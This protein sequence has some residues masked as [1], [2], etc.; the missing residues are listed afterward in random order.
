MEAIVRRHSSSRMG[1]PS[2]SPETSRAA[3]PVPLRKTVEPEKTGGGGF[4]LVL[5]DVSLSKVGNPMRK[6]SAAAPGVVKP[7]AQKPSRPNLCPS[8]PSGALSPVNSTVHAMLERA[9]ASKAANA[10]GSSFKSPAP[11]KGWFSAVTTPASTAATGRPI[12]VFDETEDWG[13]SI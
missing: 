7:L 5:K 3:S 6:A 8:S 13:L 1:S 2:S 4:S 9:A 12:E 10:S 11:V